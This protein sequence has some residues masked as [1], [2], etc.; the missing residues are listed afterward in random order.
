MSVA[1]QPGS[2]DATDG[3]LADL[4]A[5]SAEWPLNR[6][7]CV[8]GHRGGEISVHAL[9]QLLKTMSSASLDPAEPLGAVRS[10]T[11]ACT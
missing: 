5:E 8:S 3:E 1:T 4:G 10:R 9:A 7:S 11:N 6:V 2:G